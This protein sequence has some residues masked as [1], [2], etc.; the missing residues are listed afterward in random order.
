MTRKTNIF[1]NISDAEPAPVVVLE[2]YA[3]DPDRWDRIAAFGNRT[4]PDTEVS[5]PI[6]D[7]ALR[8]LSKLKSSV[9]S[10]SDI[11]LNP[12]E[13]KIVGLFAE[14]YRQIYPNMDDDT[15]MAIKKYIASANY[16]QR[17]YLQSFKLAECIIATHQS[18]S[19]T[20]RPEPF[21]NNEAI[22]ALKP[23]A[24][25]ISQALSSA[26]LDHKKE[27]AILAKQLRKIPSLSDLMRDI[28]RD[29]EALVSGYE[30]WVEEAVRASQTIGRTP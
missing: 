10:S 11:K 18:G 8:G 23:D 4:V 16:K 29:N 9:F 5:G 25:R 14:V 20:L 22:K 27:V 26:Q 17:D 19:L 28:E 21:L 6:L 7:R 13:D 15:R 12:A 1:S 2:E 24:E 3:P 30:G